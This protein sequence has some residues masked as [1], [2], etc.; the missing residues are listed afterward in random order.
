MTGMPAPT[1]ARD[2]ADHRPGALEL[3]RIGPGSL[4]RRT[5]FAT[6]SSSEAWKEPNGMSPMTSARGL[7]RATAPVSITASSMLTGTVVS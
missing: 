4:T 2:A 1:M 6:A 3:D 7:A 5:A